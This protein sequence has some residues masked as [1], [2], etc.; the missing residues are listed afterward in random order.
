MPISILPVM[1]KVF[2][3][4]IFNR[5]ENYFE[6]NIFHENQ[7]RFRKGKSRKI[8]KKGTM[9]LLYLNLSTLCKS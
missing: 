4:V 9:N 7:F 3:K 2:E 6:D 1:S 8:S 5:L